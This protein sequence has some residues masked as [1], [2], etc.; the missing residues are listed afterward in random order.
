[1]NVFGSFA[2]LLI[3]MVSWSTAST[4]Q[5]LLLDFTIMLQLDGLLMSL[6]IKYSTAILFHC[7][8][9]SIE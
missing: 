3:L 9:S 8:T 4:E 5:Q 2:T 6:S 7:F 1:L